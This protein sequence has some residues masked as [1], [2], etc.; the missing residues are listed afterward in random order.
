MAKD[1][2]WADDLLDRRE[3]AEF[4]TRTLV[5]RTASISEKQGQRGWTVALDAGWGAGKSFFV[6]RWV[7]HLR[8]EGHPVVFFDAWENDIGEEAATALMAEINEEMDDWID[9]LPKTEVARK[10]AADLVVKSARNLR[11]SVVPVAKVVA[12]GLLK[13]AIGTS[14]EEMFDAGSEAKFDAESIKSS[15]DDA[16]D[17]AFEV[18]LEEHRQRKSNIKEFKLALIGLI[19][20]IKSKAGAK[21]PLFV[22]IDELDRCRPTYAISML[23]EVKHIFGMDKVCFVVSTNLSQL[24]HSVRAVY[25]LGFD[26]ELYLKRFFDQSIEM[27]Q[28]RGRDHVVVLMNFFNEI[29]DKRNYTA[30]PGGSASHHMRVYDAISLVFDSLGLEPRSQ[31]QAFGIAASV[32]SSIASDLIHTTYLF[33]LCSLYLKNQALFDDLEKGADP[34]EICSKVMVID[35]KIS[36]E[37]PDELGRLLRQNIRLSA[38]LSEYVKL[39]RQSLSEVEVGASRSIDWIAFEV[40]QEARGMHRVSERPFIA[41]YFK[42]VRYAGYLK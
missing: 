6:E 20:L 13:K 25:G 3:F 19:D 29:T 15:A 41:E 35:E 23:E 39:S 14:I 5:A 4:L 7:R 26:S 42:L 18:A 16:L 8:L 31:K 28:S 10:T 22:F 37:Y 11:K 27:P 1:V 32:C 24:R 17:K 21:L 33:F 2:I 36:Y 9:K 34:G 12:S 30:I 38:V 40:T